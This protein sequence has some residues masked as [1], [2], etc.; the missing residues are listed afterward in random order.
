MQILELTLQTPSLGAT[1]T[2]YGDRLGLDRVRTDASGVTF[3][4]GSTRLTFVAAGPGRSPIYHFAIN[5]VPDRFDE[6]VEW[7]SERARILADPEARRTFRFPAWNADAIY[8]EDATGNIVELIARHAIGRRRA[9]SVRGGDAQSTRFGRHSLLSVSE[10]GLPVSDVPRSR[11]QL[12]ILS[13]AAPWGEPGVR[14]AALGDDDGLFIVV[15]EDRAWYPT[16]RKAAA[17]PLGV[18]VVGPREAAFQLAGTPY[19]ITTRP[20]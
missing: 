19:L 5:V 12:E 2:F 18:T 1:R 16:S 11:R 3:A 7:I 9:A 8:F 4:V 10:I 13:G 20:R 17:F 14:F 15:E 6:A